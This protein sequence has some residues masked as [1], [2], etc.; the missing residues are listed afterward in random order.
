MC[1]PLEII[2]F[3]YYVI[4]YCATILLFFLYFR[5]FPD[6]SCYEQYYG[7]SCTCLPSVPVYQ[8]GYKPVSGNA[9]HRVC[10]TS[11][12]FS[13]VVASVHTYSHQQR[14]RSYESVSLPA[15]GIA[16]CIAFIFRKRRF[17]KQTKNKNK[18]A[19]PSLP[20]NSK[21]DSGHRKWYI[22]LFL[23]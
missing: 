10:E 3:D 11:N 5:L 14:M 17:L 7:Y 18:T 12:C 13:K 23:H 4:F 20:R 6:V 16:R 8:F 22:K 15:F 2:Y 19:L 9:C 21:K 1:M